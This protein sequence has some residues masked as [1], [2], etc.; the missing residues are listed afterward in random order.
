MSW[1]FGVSSSSSGTGVRSFGTGSYFYEDIYFRKWVC[2]VAISM[3]EGR[4]D[5]FVW[6]DLQKQFRNPEKQQILPLNITKDIIDETSILYRESP[7]YKVVDEDGNFSPKDQRLFERIQRDCRY[8]ATLDKVDK[9]TK[10][11][12]TVLVKVNFI[13]ED[14]NI[15]TDSAK[16]KIQIDVLHGG[17]YDIRYTSTPYSINELL[18]GLGS[19]FSGFQA[20]PGSQPGNKTELTEI[21]WSPDKHSATKKVDGKVSTI[22][23]PID[24]PYKVIPAVP[25]FN[26]DPNHYYF[27]PV[28]EP[29]L[30]ANHAINMR[31]TD[32]N[33][34][35][36]FQS[37]GI[38]VF[39]GVERGT[40]LRRGRPVDDF[41]MFKTG[42][43]AR[44]QNNVFGGAGPS[45]AYRNYNIPSGGFTDGNA[46]ANAMGMS[47]G[48]DTAISVGEKGD[49]KFAHP[50]ADIQGLSKTIQQLQDWVR[51]SHG[52]VAKGSSDS[53]KNESGFSQMLG[54]IGVIEDNIRRQKLF[55]DREQQLFQ[56]IK[57]V[58]NAHYFKAGEE[59]FSEDCRLEITYVE[60]TFAVDPQTKI[61]V[62]EGQRKIIESG[63]RRAIKELFKHLDDKQINELIKQTH[64]DRLEQAERNKELQE[65]LSES[66]EDSNEIAPIAK[67]A[68]S[69]LT[70]M[71]NRMKHS[72]ESSI[73]PNKGLDSRKTEK[74][75]K[76]EEYKEEE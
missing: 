45:G 38:P 31:L 54:K 64:K 19:G 12:G 55:M 7:V 44:A 22:I 46:D 68:K 6:M 20:V 65:I 18:I 63:D 15:S 3:Y 47:I 61:I 66:Q 24:N 23:E 50:G 35:A 37:F 75:K 25:F 10:L 57:S 30:Y 52:L 40:S 14:G 16:G 51:I 60:P 69:S 56:V 67:G 48:P 2:E 29:L 34:I 39:S 11:L 17:M 71:D 13:D 21:Y 73:Q 42:S 4:Q 41:N 59:R 76:S 53:N 28:N 72:E 8:L 1:N 43:P 58:W 32:L 74:T 36:K 5:H 27:L 49:F 62:L 26:S 33:H 9:F 70:G